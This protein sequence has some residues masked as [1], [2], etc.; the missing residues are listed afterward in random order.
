MIAKS[1]TTNQAQEQ[2]AA[3]DAV[4]WLRLGALAAALALSAYGYRY[5]RYGEEWW[6]W[7]GSLALASALLCFAFADD[8]KSPES[9]L[10]R[11][12]RDACGLV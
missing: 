4:A 5:Y 12:L 3:V 1:W 10:R 2:S 7:A 11:G 9:A 8:V 6:Y